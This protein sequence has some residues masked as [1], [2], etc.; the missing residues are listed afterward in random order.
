MSFTI[1]LPIYNLNHIFNRTKFLS[2]FPDSLISN[3]L[4]LSSDETIEMTQPCLI[5][6]IIQL[7]W[8]IIEHGNYKSYIPSKDLLKVGN[9]L[10]IDLLVILGSPQWKYFN[11]EFP[12]INLLGIKDAELPFQWAIENNYIPLV[13]YF[14]KNG[15]DPSINNNGAI[16]DASLYGHLQLVNLLLKDERVDSSDLGNDA[17]IEA[18]A[19]GYLDIVN[20]LLLDPRVNPETY[21]IIGASK[22]GHIDV[23]TRLL[24]DERVKPNKDAVRNATINGHIEIV[25]LLLSHPKIDPT[26]FQRYNYF[27]YT[28]IDRGYFE[29]AYFVESWIIE[30]DGH[31]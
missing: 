23:V 1:F 16:Q 21:P 8:D 31:I 7:L 18:S 22:N 17:I 27:V 30:H 9:Y 13:T 15:I 26:E 14:I 28:A 4:D 12:D 24:K 25:K 6:D 3:V 2:L 10:N 19:R 5:P 20:R 11:Y 29:V